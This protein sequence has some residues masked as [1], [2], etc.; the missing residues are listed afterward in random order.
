MN[1]NSPPYFY[2]YTSKPFDS[3]L[4]IEMAAYVLFLITHTQ[5]DVN[6]KLLYIH[7]IPIT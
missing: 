2:S 6:K 3:I 1:D 7:R 5:L 4:S